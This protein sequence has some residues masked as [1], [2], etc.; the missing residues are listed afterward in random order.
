[1]FHFI[2]DWNEFRLQSIRDLQSCMLLYQDEDYGNSAYLLQQGLEKYVKAYLFKFDL[3][4]GNPRKLRHLTL[5]KIWESLIHNIQKKIDS[6]DKD[7]KELFQQS[8]QMIEIIAKFFKKIE[9]GEDVRYKYAMWKHSLGVELNSQEKGVL[10]YFNDQMENELT[11]LIAVSYTKFIKTLARIMPLITSD[12][13]KKN[14]LESLVKTITGKSLDEVLDQNPYGAPQNLY[15]IASEMPAFFNQLESLIYEIM[16]ITKGDESFLQTDFMKS[17]LIAWI[18]SIKDELI[19][20]FPHED[21]GRYPVT[22]EGS[23]SRWIYEQKSV[24]LNELIIKGKN[25]CDKVEKML[26]CLY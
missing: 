18:L 5:P 9:D 14:A 25:A 22:I 26:M 16:K 3:F 24:K 13:V 11:P 10:K 7:A 1:M 20:T 21:L 2:V 19:F 4:I 12:P 8:L 17:L 6:S 15:E 23:S